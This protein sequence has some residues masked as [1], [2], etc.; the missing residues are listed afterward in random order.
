MTKQLDLIPNHLQELLAL[1]RK[2]AQAQ[3]PAEA[4]AMFEAQR[5]SWLR[6]EQ[7]LGLDHAD[8]A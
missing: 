7:A 6:G 2:E 8:Q 4:A 3:T 1:A 5:Q